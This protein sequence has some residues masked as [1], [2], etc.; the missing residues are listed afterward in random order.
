MGEARREF[1]ITSDSYKEAF[2]NSI[3]ESEDE[4]NQEWVYEIISKNST[5]MHD[6]MNMEN[7]D[8]L[9]VIGYGIKNGIGS[10]DFRILHEIEHCIDLEKGGQRARCGFDFNESE[11]LNPY[12][13]NTRKY[14]M[15]N[16]TITD[17]FAIEALRI[18]HGQGKY[19][20]EPEE[21]VT[22]DWI[23]QNSYPEVLKKI[24]E[25][26]I[27][28]YRD[29]IIRSKVYGDFKCLYDIIGEE[30][31]EEIND[32]VNR[33]YYLWNQGL[34]KEID[35]NDQE[36]PI[37]VEYNE[38]LKRL[39][40]LYDRMDKHNK[41]GKIS[42]EDL[43]NTLISETEKNVRMREIEDGMIRIVEASKATREP[44]KDNLGEGRN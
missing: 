4:N 15:L 31:F 22:T 24:L 39:Q 33:V 1:I 23:Y 10:L 36:S 7:G 2:N 44:L 40:R 38:I 41:D 13:K 8:I 29:E 37:V 27:E 17:L 6:A 19:I 25:P 35:E 9:G 34:K 11:E 20:I 18:L 14:E 3:L 30:N 28:K 16:E 42:G 21:Y 32:I 5:C 43:L 12:D 26:F